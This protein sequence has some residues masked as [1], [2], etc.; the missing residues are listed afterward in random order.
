VTDLGGKR[1]EPTPYELNQYLSPQSFMAKYLV[2][3]VEKG[4]TSEVMH[5]ISFND[6]KTA[7][8]E[9]AHDHG[10]EPEEINNSDYYDVSIWGWTEDKYQKIYGY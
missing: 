3:V 7:F 2:V 1:E 10:Y 4:I 9:V 6:A 8:G 5:F